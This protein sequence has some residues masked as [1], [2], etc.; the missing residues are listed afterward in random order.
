MPETIKAATHFGWVADHHTGQ[1]DPRFDQP[2]LVSVSWNRLGDVRSAQGDLAGRSRPT[3]GKEI[4]EQLAAADPGNAE[5]QRDLSVSW[6]KLGDVRAAQGDLAGALQAY[7]GAGHRREAGG[8]GPRQRRVAARPVAQLE[9][10]RRRAAGPGRPR[11]G[12]PGLQRRPR[13]ARSWRPPTP[14]TPSW[15]R[16]LS[17]SWS[18]RRH[19]RAAG[20]QGRGP[21]GVAAGA[22]G[23]PAAGQGAS[24]QR[25]HRHLG[26][27]PCGRRC[28]NLPDDDKAGG[29]ELGA[30][31][32]DLLALLQPL[33]DCRSARRSAGRL[34][35]RPQAGA[36][37]PARR[38]V[39]RRG[40]RQVGP[41]ESRAAR[42][43]RDW[44]CVAVVR[45]AGT[46]HRQPRRSGR[47]PCAFSL[48]PGPAGEFVAG[49]AGRDGV[50]QP[51]AHDRAELGHL[52]GAAG[53][54]DGGGEDS[55]R[56]ARKRSSGE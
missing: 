15:Q 50:G 4:L 48:A 46:C 27:G 31:A 37:G 14:A 49:H 23:Q 52:A 33:A 22:G 7:E 17:V 3:R 12:A 2:D 5:W 9:Q 28:P 40:A 16:D 39:L 8:R 18:G 42:A 32:S 10:A 24:G 47:R 6:N 19:P 21:Q 41:A 25:R 43:S 13:S 53:G 45:A 54:V 51:L 56:P 38:V 11:G 20:R 29:E 34:G 30:Q 1:L 55:S 44:A 35:G 26:G 36:G